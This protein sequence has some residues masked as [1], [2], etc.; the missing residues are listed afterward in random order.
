[1][2]ESYTDDESGDRYISTNALEDIIDRNYV[3]TVINARYSRLKIHDLI[4]K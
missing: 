1:M 2:D 3:H 4:G